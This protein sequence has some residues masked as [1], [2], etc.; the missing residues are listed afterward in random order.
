MAPTVL[1]LEDSLCELGA[2]AA[3]S[4][5][6]RT[7]RLLDDVS[8]Y[9]NALECSLRRATSPPTAYDDAGVM[10]DPFIASRKP[11]S[12]DRSSLL[13]R[14]KSPHRVRATPHTAYGNGRSHS[15]LSSLVAAHLTLVCRVA[16]TSWPVCP[17]PGGA[18]TLPL[19]A[20]PTFV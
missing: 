7:D 10:H 5:A 8:S 19:V 9:Q 20:Y 13:G 6:T 3:R 18:G 11:A 4:A 1:H 15:M 16:P 12:I 2:Q 14:R 17:S